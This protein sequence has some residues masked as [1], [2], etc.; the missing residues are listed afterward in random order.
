MFPFDAILFDVGGVLLTNGWDHNERAAAVEHFQLDAK[1]L[2]ARHLEVFPAWERDE[3]GVDAYLE[4]AVFHK[5]RGFSRDEFFHFILNQSKLLPDSALSILREVAASHKYMVGALNNEARATNDYRF[6][7]F[8]LRDYFEVAF[9]S[10]FV[11][12]R[13]PEPDIYRRALDILGR[14]PQ[15]V[16]FIDD[17]QQNTDAAATAGMKTICYQGSEALRREFENLGV[18]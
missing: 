9:S 4:H 10:C 12:M 1:D 7:K 17:R 3:I 6:S 16:L 5:A 18:F 13:K 15:R 8:G 2:E 14:P 11:G